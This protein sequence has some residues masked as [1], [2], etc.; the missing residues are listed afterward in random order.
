MPLVG[1]LSSFA[2][3]EVIALLMSGGKSGRLSLVR[4]GDE[5]SLS[6]EHGAIVDAV[7]G[8]THGS[9]ALSDILTAYSSGRFVFSDGEHVQEPTMYVD[10]AQ[11]AAM[12]VVPA[13]GDR[14]PASVLLN[15][16]EKLTVSLPQT[17]YPAL[18]PLQWLLLAEIPRRCTLRHLAQDRDAVA[19]KNALAVLLR[20]GFVTGTGQI[21]SP[22][23]A[24]V[25]LTVV[26][27]YTRE[28]EVVALDLDIVSRWRTAGCFTGKVSVAGQVFAAA[29]RQGLG[30]SIV[31]SE[32]ACRLCGVRDAQEVDV[33]AVS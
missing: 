32:A 6:F 11:L 22:V 21:L 12:T 19:V 29:G 27:G 7:H 20:E 18:T 13:T 17:E 1:D 2:V 28:E 8:S 5:S 23:A 31:I 9:G 25:R 16:D 4:D 15:A 33:T 30:R 24:G 26:K 3:D 14:M 10:A